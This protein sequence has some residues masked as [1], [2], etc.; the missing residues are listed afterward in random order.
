MKTCN[1]CRKEKILTDFIK[2]ETREEAYNYEK[3]LLKENIK[4]EHCLNIRGW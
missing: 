4:Q 3:F 1:K 2:F